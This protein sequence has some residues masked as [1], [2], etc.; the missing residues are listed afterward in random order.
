MVS[1]APC[2]A[3]PPP[4][5]RAFVRICLYP[6]S[7]RRSLVIRRRR[8]RRR[9]RFLYCLRRI[10]SSSSF[11]CL[12]FPSVSIPPRRPVVPSSRCIRPRRLSCRLQEV[13]VRLV[14]VKIVRRREVEHFLTPS[15]DD[16]A[17]QAS[18]SDGDYRDGLG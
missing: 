18:K 5:A 11:P 7:L 16:F 10:R 15:S 8:R 4:C 12:A 1:R 9:C 17:L 2:L 6:G 14:C 13:S 3:S